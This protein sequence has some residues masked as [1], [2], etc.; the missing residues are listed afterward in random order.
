MSD[1]IEGFSPFYDKN[2]RVLILGSFPSV[3]S[4][5]VDFYY[6]NKQNRF[7]KILYNFFGEEY[8]ED[9]SSKKD[10]LLRNQVALWD[11][12]TRCEI[13]GSRDD[14]IQ[15]YEIADLSIVLAEAPIEKILLN[16]KTAYRIFC[17]KYKEIEVPYLL[18][19]STSPAN[20]HCDSALWQKALEEIFF[21]KKECTKN[22][23]L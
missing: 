13:E 19:P 22:N 12:V 11:I 6:G 16:G 2:S 20:T 17:E 21:D 9:T 3:K 23:Q 18:M 7:W 5:K 10:F 15:N 1:R 4:R 14:S 8:K